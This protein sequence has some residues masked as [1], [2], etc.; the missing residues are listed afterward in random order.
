MLSTPRSVSLWTST[1]TRLLIA[2]LIPVGGCA[3]TGSLVPSVSSH[4]RVSPEFVDQRIQAFF[5]YL[6][7]NGLLLHA[8]MVGFPDGYWDPKELDPETLK[9][10]PP[11]GILPWDLLKEL[12]PDIIEGLTLKKGTGTNG[13]QQR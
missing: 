13:S 11:K 6:R 3:S 10:L 5:N 12:P 4:T 1:L 2:V 9:R 7:V 8:P